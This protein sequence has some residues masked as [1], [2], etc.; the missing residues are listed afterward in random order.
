[1]IRHI[2]KNA[3]QKWSAWTPLTFV[4]K[5]VGSKVDISIRFVQ[6]SHKPCAVPFDGRDGTI[7][8]AYYP[9]KGQGK[10]VKLFRII[11]D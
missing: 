4:E 6:K 5:P 3:F 2:L 8:H 7:A 9:Y 11:F 10:V 1:M